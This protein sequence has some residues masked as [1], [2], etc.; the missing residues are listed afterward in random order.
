MNKF[1]VKCGK[2]INIKL[3]TKY[4]PTEL[5]GLFTMAMYRFYLKNLKSFKT[6][7]FDKQLTLHKVHPNGYIEYLGSCY[8]KDLLQHMGLRR[9]E[10]KK[11]L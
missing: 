11:S 8:T 10:I 2:K 7:R 3:E 9:Y 1:I 6:K 5:S 4:Q